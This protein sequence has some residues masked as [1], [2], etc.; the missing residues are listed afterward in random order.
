MASNLPNQT[1]LGT[2][3]ALGTAG[4]PNATDALL[5]GVQQGERT[6]VMKALEAGADPNTTDALALAVQHGQTSIVE[7]LLEHAQVDPERMNHNL[8]TP[9]MLAASLGNME[10]LRLLVAHPDVGMNV[11]NPER[12][13]A[14]CFDVLADNTEAVETLLAAGA[15]PVVPGALN[16][17]TL[18]YCRDRRGLGSIQAIRRCAVFRGQF[19]FK[20]DVIL[21]SVCL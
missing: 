6:T 14:L 3:D 12:N 15:N 11:I 4:E 18:A 17:L 20:L 13:T 10:I 16:A 19:F 7:L 5:R 1:A 8:Q 2:A 21:S 9:L